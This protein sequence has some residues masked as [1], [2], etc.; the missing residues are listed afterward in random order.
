MTLSKFEEALVYTTQT[1]CRQMRKQTDV[2]YIAHVLGVTAIA[3]E[4]GA[5]EMEA[6]AALLHDVVEDCGGA[7]RLREIGERFGENVAGIVE[8]RTASRTGR[9]PFGL[10]LRAAK[11]GTLWYY[12]SLVAAFRERGKRELINELEEIVD[13]MTLLAE[14]KQI[15][16]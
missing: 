1:H 11:K 16:V 4:Y 2:P 9:Q 8:G 5:T 14:A 6:I 15:E 3:L 12:K 7:P 10:A 13:Q